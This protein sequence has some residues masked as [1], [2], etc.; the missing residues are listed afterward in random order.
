MSDNI[1]IEA[2]PRTLIGKKVA[3][4]RREG[5]VPATVYGKGETISV[6][7]ERKALRRALRVVG[8]TQMAQLEV[9]GK[10][11]PVLVRDIQQHLTRG[12][13]LHV[14]FLVIDMT[15]TFK[16]EAELVPIGESAP[17]A[18]GLGVGV[19]ALRSVEIEALADAL[20]SEIEVDLSL[21]TDPDVVITIADLV[22][23][24]GVT[25]LADPDT[26]VAR[27][28]YVS[29][30]D[31][32]EEDELEDEFGVVAEDVEVIGKGKQDEDEEAFE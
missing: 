6:Q 8:T 29:L 3:Q 21:I 18:E 5:W 4:L 15:S 23:P 32:E 1:V 2:E 7:I 31:E 25:I 9:E 14:D 10:Q 30:P 12:D 13:V 26:A 19:L 11:R 28:E 20:I 24:K 27:F 22:V 16:V 17:G